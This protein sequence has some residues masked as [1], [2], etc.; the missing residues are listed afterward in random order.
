M[1]PFR[2]SGIGFNY[3]VPLNKAL[4]PALTGTHWQGVPDE[5]Q[6]IIFLSVVIRSNG[7]KRGDASGDK[8]PCQ[9]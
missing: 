5:S 7:T 1:I 6:F 8:V 4:C 3:P 2:T 9:H